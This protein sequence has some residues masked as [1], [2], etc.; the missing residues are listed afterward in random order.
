[1]STNTR[2]FFEK[3]QQSWQVSQAACR[4]ASSGTLMVRIMKPQLVTSLLGLAI[5][6]I[7]VGCGPPGIPLPPSLNLPT[8]VADLRAVRK[9]DK[10]YLAW[11]LPRE[12]TDRTSIRHLGP[13]KICRTVDQDMSACGIAVGEA[14]PPTIAPVA[15][16]K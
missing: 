16:G 10:V 12:T 9:G 14:P 13:T 6:S 8:P 2:W 4:R 5:T 11:T 1:M 15:A 7:L 3:R